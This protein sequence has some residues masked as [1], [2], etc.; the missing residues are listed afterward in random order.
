MLEIACADTAAARLECHFST[1]QHYTWV[2]DCVG[3]SGVTKEHQCCKK[4]LSA[5][6]PNSSVQRAHQTQDSLIFATTYSSNV[7]IYAS[8]SAGRGRRAHNKAM[9]G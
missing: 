8:V 4:V 7:V 3:S 2:S 9:R 6:A 5:A 1:I